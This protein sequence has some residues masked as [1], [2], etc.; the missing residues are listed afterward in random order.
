MSRDGS[1]ELPF[2][3]E[4]RVFRLRAG[5]WRAVQEKCDAGPAELARRYGDGTWRVDDLREPLL[6]GL[7]GGGMPQ[8]EASRLII[9]NF[10]DRPMLQF[11]PL[12]QALV[13]ATLVG[14]PD[15]DKSSGEGAG[16]AKP[17]T[18]SRAARSGSRRSTSGA[19][20][21]ATR[22]AKSTT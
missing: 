8:P 14:A 2:A 20:P 17:E 21:K 16:E 5:H 6:Q 4:E 22:R 10:D 19:G 7:Q 13:L 3:G 15:E 18:P 9:S 11:V 1:I 12:A